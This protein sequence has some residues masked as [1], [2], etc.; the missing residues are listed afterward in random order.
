MVSLSADEVNR[1]S[2][3]EWTAF[4]SEVKACNGLERRR[5]LHLAYER[6]HEREILR[7]LASHRRYRGLS[8]PAKAGP[9]RRC[10]SALT[11]ARN[12]CGARSKKLDPEVETFSS[13][14]Y[15]GVAVDY[16]GIDDPH[17]AA[18]CPVVV[19]PQH[20]VL[21]QPKAED[22]ALLESRRWRRRFLG[23]LMRNSFVSSRTLGARL[24]VDDGA[25][26]AFGGPPDRPSAGAPAL[27]AAARVAEQGVSAGAAHGTDVDAQHRA[28]AGRG[29]GS[30]DGLR[31]RRK[32]PKEWQAF[33]VRRAWRAAS[34]A[35][36]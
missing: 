6:W 28:I 36:W 15:F 2:D 35:S 24:A 12:P 34:P 7:G 22:S 27:R 29:D 19:K 25:G 14:G 21:E 16:K 31:R 5:I 20:A 33:W 10:S 8:R 4:V 13:A 17:G 32:K 26:I 18:F 30:V 3:A 1:L 9:P 11:S 23:L